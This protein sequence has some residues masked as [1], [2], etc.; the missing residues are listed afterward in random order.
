MIGLLGPAVTVAALTAAFGR[1]PSNASWAQQEGGKIV[2]RNPKISIEPFGTMD[3]L[4]VER[5][6]LKNAGGTEVRILT[7]G[8]IIQSISVPDRDGSLANVAL[9][10]A[11][12]D[13]YVG[14][15]PYFGCITG[16]Y[17][18]RIAKGRFTLDGQTYELATNN[19]PNSLHGGARG[20]DKHVWD[21]S[22]VEGGGVGLRLRRTSPAG[23]EGYPGTLEAEVTYTLTDNDEVR[24]D[25]RATTD[26]TTVVNLTNHSYFNLGGEGTGTVEDHELQ[27]SAVAYTPTD[28]T[29]IPTGE[30]VPVAGTPFD[31]TVPTPI[32][33]RIRDATAQLVFAQGY[34]HNFVLDRPRPGDATLI[35]AARLHDPRSGR[36]M[37][38]STTEPGLQVYS[39]NYLDGTLVGASG[40]TY[41]QGDGLALE[42]QHF[43]DS[44]NQPH[45]PSTV[46][47]PGEEYRSTTVYA[48]S[49]SAGA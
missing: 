26:Q 6:T 32:G 45:F 18:N 37:E 11:T 49:T 41:R 47:R 42:T 29:A 30:I 21:A 19:G 1:G 15:S 24:I 48:F 16:R 25:Y 35:R 22:E 40:K 14:A 39:G 33:A 12:L 34:D 7:Y 10:F 8:G 36:T 4:S 31:F 17:A 27:I 43:P 23:E 20:F 46:L 5:Y 44:P 3:G 9:G 13:G 2:G 38:V 28:E